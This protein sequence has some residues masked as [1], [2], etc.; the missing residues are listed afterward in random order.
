LIE[1]LHEVLNEIEYAWA[2]KRLLVVGD[3]MLDK[4]I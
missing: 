3:L 4:Y 2:A 1:Q